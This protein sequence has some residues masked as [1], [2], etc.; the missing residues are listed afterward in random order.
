MIIKPE[1]SSMLPIGNL[2]NLYVVADFDKTITNGSS[3]TSW[4]ILAS[5][6]LVPESY[7]DERQALY[8]F[9]RPIEVSD[10][11]EYSYKLQ[12]TKEWFQK[13]IELFIKYQLSKEVFEEAATNLRVMEFRPYAREFIEFLHD[14]NIPLIIISAG[15]GNFIE[16]F[17]EHN[18]CNFDNI[19]ISSNKIIFDDGIAVGVGENIIHSFNKNEVSLPDDILDKIRNRDSVILLGDQVSDLNMVDRDIHSSVLSIGFLTTDFSKEVLAAN[20]DIVCE[21]SDTYDD[22][23]KILFNYNSK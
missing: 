6:D 23:K 4:S 7:I 9:Y 20:F 13:H 14:N 12:M 2:D 21:E 17:L 3:K 1:V 16:S 8:D 19:Y 18:N 15:I 5:S 22:V 10:T 11:A